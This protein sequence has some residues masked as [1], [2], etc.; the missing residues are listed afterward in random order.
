[1]SGFDDEREAGLIRIEILDWIDCE[2][3]EHGRKC[4]MLL[5]EDWLKFVDLEP[6]SGHML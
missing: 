3:V 6:S 4:N 1:M 2:R 5:V